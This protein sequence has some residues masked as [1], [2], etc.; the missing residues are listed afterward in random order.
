M[1]KWILM[2]LLI[3]TLPACQTA[4]PYKAASQGDSFYGYK[5]KKLGPNLY[6]VSFRG[7]ENTSRNQVERYM[8]LRVAELAK[9]E[10]KQYVEFLERDS[11][12]ITEVDKDYR[13]VPHAYPSVYGS[14]SIN[15][16]RYPYYP[17][18]YGW[19]YQAQPVIDIEERYTSTAYVR[20]HDELEKGEE[21]VSRNII[22]DN[23]K[24]S[25]Q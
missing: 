20:F 14:M 17:V 22:L 4:T 18:G 3:F 13:N 10:D 16:F 8:G 11:K 2:S 21:F 23:V 12:E 24:T 1:T 25:K 6:R 9:K 15:R 7:N 5:A 19:S